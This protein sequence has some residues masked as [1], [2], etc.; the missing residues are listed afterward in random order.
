MDVVTDEVVIEAP[1]AVVWRVLTSAPEMERWFASEVRLEA[2]VGSV[3]SMA[4][5]DPSGEAR[6]RTPLTVVEVDEPRR[7]AYRWE[8]DEAEAPGPGNSMLVVFELDDLGESTR[9]RVTESGFDRRGWAP[10]VVEGTVNDHVT[11][12]RE[13]LARLGALGAGQR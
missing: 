1:V 8:Y 6:H 4:F 10:D 2:R 9:V 7:F 11:G 12:W 5:N 3:G 13:V